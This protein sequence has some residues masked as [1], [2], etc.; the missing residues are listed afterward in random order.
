MFTPMMGFS[1]GEKIFVIIGNGDFVLPLVYIDNLC[2]V[3]IRVIEKKEGDG[4][5]FNI[6]DGGNVTKQ[7][8]V[9]TLIKKLY[10][11][12]KVFYFPLKLLH[13]IVLL[14]EWLMAKVGRN[15]ILTRYRLI[16]SQRKILYDSS[17]I[18][19]MLSWTP[20]VTIDDGIKTVLDFE[21]KSG[22]L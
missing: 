14:Q 4:E 11:Q 9:N 16:S 7:H 3:V 8:Y 12:A 18:S 10:P 22:N 15:P 6:I 2:D 5:I 13:T 17:K 20:P 21:R 1:L 19:R